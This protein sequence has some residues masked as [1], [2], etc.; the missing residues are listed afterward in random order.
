MTRGIVIRDLRTIPEF[1]EVMALEHDIWGYGEAEDAVGVPMFVVTVKRGGIL[2][3]AYDGGRMAGFVYS[4]AGLRHGQPVQWSHMLGVRPEYRGLGLGR[5]LKLDQRRRA[6]A[7]GVDLME[8]TYDPLQALNAHLNFAR[9]G[10]I[11]EEY[12][13]NVYGESSSTLH[14]GNPTDRFIAQWWMRSTRVVRLTEGDPA[15]VRTAREGAVPHVLQAPARGD[16][17]EPARV[18]LGRTDAALAVAVP[19]GFT[20]MLV[21]DPGLAEAWRLASREVFSH[22]LGRGYRVVDFA[23]DPASGGGAYGL[24]ASRPADLDD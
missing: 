9:L 13:V 14:K 18:E 10:T 15:D 19:G 7:M 21:R 1:R 3:G 8:W 6:L 24:S 12:H 11:V 22:Y 2:L 5:R 4:L 23:F 16:W 17:T 20:E